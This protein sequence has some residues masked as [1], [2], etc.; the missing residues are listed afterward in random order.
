MEHLFMGDSRLPSVEVAG[1]WTEM[2]EQVGRAFSKLIHGHIEA[3]LE[4]VHKQ[5]EAS[6]QTILSAANTFA[7]PIK[8]HAPFLW[9]E[10]LGISRGSGSTVPEILL[11]QARAEVMRICG[12]RVPPNNL[13]NECTL[14]A[15]WGN[16]VKDG[17]VLLGQNV[18]LEP[19]IREFTVVVRQRPEE[20]PAA[21]ICTSA[22]LL[23][24][25]GINETGV[26]VC[27]SFIDDPKGWGDGLPR[28]LL[29]RL[30]LAEESAGNA[31]QAV[32]KPPRAASRNLLIADS[33][34]DCVDIE[35][36]VKEAALL[37]TENNLLLHAN[38]LEVPEF[39][40][41]EEPSENSLLRRQRIQDLF[42]NAESLID[43][44]DIQQL[45]RDHGNT[46]NS[47]CAHPFEGRD[48]ETVAAV[49]GNLTEKSFYV[50]KGPP[51]KGHFEKFSF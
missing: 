3:W 45:L 17:G 35:L 20:K 49:I 9:E 24:Q 23:G 41:R 16:R 12:K 40:S 4:H 47:L 5:T 11:L 32:L 44:S 10:L 46:P 34:G 28:Y 33:G 39:L 7:T 38:H 25:N 37:R 48:I 6:R 18:D 29:S 13:D 8:N 50:C 43:I 15:V 30:V 42:E 36:L 22:G 21:I 27:A 26:G 19:F 1:T 51:C 31:V 14:F 2:G